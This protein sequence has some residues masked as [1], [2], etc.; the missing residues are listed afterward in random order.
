MDMDAITSTMRRKYEMLCPQLNERAYRLCAA[1]EARALGHG[2]VTCVAGACGLSRTTI[3]AGMAEL[4]TARSPGPVP[5]V[6]RIR[7]PGAGRKLLSAKD[8]ALLADLERL[9]APATRGDPM[10]PL[11][12][13][14][15]STTKLA[16]ELRRTGHRVSQRSVWSLLS[17][18]GYSMQSNRKTREGRDHPDRDAQFGYLAGKVQEFLAAKQPVISV[19]TKK[20]ELVGDFKNGG[21]EW[22]RKG[23]P[24]AVNVHDFPDK[25]LGKAIPYGVY[26][27]GRNQGWASVGITHDTAE[28]A[29]E[30]IRRWWKTMGR[31]V[32]PKATDLLITADGGGSNGSRVRL[33]KFQLQRLATDL[34][35]TIHVCHFPPGTS[36]WN[37]IEHRMF[38]H[39]TANWRG[40]PLKSWEAVVELISNTRTEKGLAILAALDEGRYEPG[41]KIPDEVM[42]NLSVKPCEFHGE[43]N[44]RIAPSPS[45]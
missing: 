27:V 2:G 40:R 28:F 16:G 6:R 14:C 9:V 41:T 39:I 25:H 26:D 45:S 23:E 4:A 43:W 22:E 37:K 1:A 31:P 42:A 32:Y 20:K 18:L 38:S 33:W 44:Y 3:H 30:T 29:V 24:V 10:S 13:T 34:G 21:R 7:R 35:L 15:K 8:P 5:V 12:W 11:R 17:Q 36:K 19:D